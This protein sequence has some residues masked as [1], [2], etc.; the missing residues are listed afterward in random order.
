MQNFWLQIVED[1][2]Q[3][4]RIHQIQ[5]NPSVSR[6]TTTVSPLRIRAS[7]QI[8]RPSGSRT[9]SIQDI[10]NPLPVLNSSMETVLAKMANA[11][12]SL[13]ETD[14]IEVSKQLVVLIKDCADCI[15][16]LKSATAVHQ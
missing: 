5:A 15:Q 14:D 10:Q 6:S 1:V 9:V 7:T 4:R 2:V 13:A 12:D 8:S 11:T 3:E 16:S